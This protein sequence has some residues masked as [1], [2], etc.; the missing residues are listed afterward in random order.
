M[1]DNDQVS[2]ALIGAGNIAGFHAQA[3]DQV[4]G[5][6]LAAVCCRGAESGRRFA[7]ERGGDYVGDID[8]LLARSDV[9]AV[10]VTTPSGSHADIGIRAAR[11]GKHVL[12][13]KPIDISLDRID[14]LV[15]A[16]ES[17]GVHLGAIFQSRTGEGAQALKSAVESG[18][19]GK[20]TQCS[21][22]IPWHRS[23]EYYA[24]GDWRGT[25]KLDG[26]GA[27]MNQGIHAIDLLL[28]LAGD[29]IEVS[30]RCQTRVH[31]GIEVEDNAVA[32]LGF[33][34]GGLGIV[35]GSTCTYP[36]LGKRI[37][38]LGERGSAILEDDVIKTWQFVDEQPGDEELLHPAKPSGIRGGAS[39]PKS[40]SAEGH[41]RQYADFVGA[42]RDG[43]TA[44]VSGREAR[45]PVE[46]ILAIYRSSREDAI[47][48]LKD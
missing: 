8:V 14:A 39:D 27:L 38:I 46:L 4:P 37:E 25:W 33:A 29:V 3:I 23:A 34:N 19:F 31:T 35:Q 10:A 1:A 24:S 40:I 22:Y 7:A 45:R 36:G 42:V 44:L 26:G 32:W 9:D 30:A 11:A 47:V 28:W 18:R 2:F 16:C 41:R 48:R 5:A 21:A 13:E 12:C 43:G 20:L 6:R 15:E 17:N